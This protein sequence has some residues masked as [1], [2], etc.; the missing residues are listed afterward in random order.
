VP[1][2]VNVTNGG[3]SWK[4]AAVPINCANPTGIEFA[5]NLVNRPPGNSDSVSVRPR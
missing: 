3:T 1:V 2:S 4:G 5:C